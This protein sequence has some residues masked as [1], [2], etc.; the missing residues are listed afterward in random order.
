MY[1]QFYNLFVAS[2]RRMGRSRYEPEKISVQHVPRT[3]TSG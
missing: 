2:S 1:I 3:F